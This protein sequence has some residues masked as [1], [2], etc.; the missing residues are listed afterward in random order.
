MSRLVLT[1]EAL[2]ALKS[3]FASHDEE[4]CALLFGRAVEVGGRLARIV[5]REVWY[6]KDDAYLKRSPVAAQLR[7]EVVAWAAQR[8][9]KTGE[10]VVFA[11]SHPMEFNSFS[12]TDDDGEARLKAFL[13]RRTAGT[14]HAALV[15]SPS[16]MKARIL[17]TEVDLRILGVGPTL[18]ISDSPARD[19]DNE[20]FDRQIR[21]FGTLGQQVLSRLR[22]GIVGAGGTGNPICQELAH[23]GV[24]RFLLIDPDTV[25]R[26]NLNRLVGAGPRDVG[27]RKVDV[28]ARL[29]HSINPNANV[30]TSAT[31]VLLAAHAMELADVDIA[32]C[33][34]DSQGSRA[35]LNQLAYQFLVP[36]IDMGVAIVAN[37]EKVSRIV[38]RAQ[39]L[40]PGL[41]CLVCG[42]LLNPEAVRVDLLTEFE[43]RADPYIVGAHEPAPSVISLNSTMASI[44][45][46][47][48]L[49]A[50]AGI[51]AKARL[52]NYNAV[53]GTMRPGAIPPHSGCYVCAREGSLARAGEWPLPARL[54]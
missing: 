9:R 48:F 19:I 17:G 28:T 51:P 2:E 10:S 29:I 34:T 52:V 41:G 47:M 11:H 14:I 53:N 18:Q 33:C 32:F 24:S 49:S 39:M 1:L 6:P 13:D 42:N 36:T 16:A 45:V 5:V 23:L 35:V 30:E 27:A 50:V 46:T 15:I 40:A 20:L 31:S 54:I 22:V 12:K 43:R 21:L 7:P 8:S 26:S 3:T 37:G 4:T 25:E 38:G 44:A